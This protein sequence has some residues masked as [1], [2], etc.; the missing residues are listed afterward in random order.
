MSNT[1]ATY[2]RRSDSPELSD[3]QILRQGQPHAPQ[4]AHTAPRRVTHM[5]KPQPHRLC[6]KHT[7]IVFTASPNV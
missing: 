6:F 3:A 4:A 1:A 7:A 2:N 5:V